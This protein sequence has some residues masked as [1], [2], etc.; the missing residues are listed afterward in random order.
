MS[1]DLG[2][3][4]CDE[5]LS[6]A[7]KFKLGFLLTEKSHEKTW[8]LSELAKNNLP[9]AI[10]VLKDL[11]LNVL[12]VLSEKLDQMNQ[13]AEKIEEVFADGGKVYLFGCG[14]T[15]R[16]SLLIESIWNQVH[17]DKVGQV[18][19]FMSGGDIALVQSVEGFEDQ[20]VYGAR[21]LNDL[22]FGEKD[23]LISSTEGGETPIVIGATLEATK[24]SKHKCYYLYC[25]PT[26]LLVDN[27][28]RSRQAIHHERVEPI[29]LYCG[30]MG[31][32]GSTRMQASSI[33]QIFISMAL[34][35]QKPGSLAGELEGFK[36]FFEQLDLS[37]L[38]A[39]IKE[40]AGIYVS[41]GR[42]TYNVDPQFALNTFTDTTERAPTF[43]MKPF[44]HPNKMEL[45]LALCYICVNG[46][47]NS[48]D[49]WE[50]LLFRKPRALGWEDSMA[51]VSDEYLKGFD[52][53][54]HAIAKR[55]KI[56]PTN[57]NFNITA[58]EGFLSWKLND[59]EYNI[60]LPKGLQFHWQ[61]VLLKFI[62]NTH[63]T[64]IMGRLRRYENNLM[65]WVSP[66]NGKLIDRTARYVDHFLKADGISKTYEEIVKAIFE[67]NL[68]KDRSM[69]LEIY[70]HI[71][72]QYEL[73][74]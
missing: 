14:A 72:R 71:K 39:F 5:Y 18:V 50:K 65:T 33:L 30:S 8:N 55:Q 41:F 4:N 69:V 28:E 46:A 45:P 24:I 11:D 10:N 54:H 7:Q 60:S 12:S 44:E 6:V 34:F 15:G 61:Q 74:K 66:S 21:H 73:T 47:E 35:R 2:F 42:L 16:L 36:K 3:K 63:S 68:R 26:D 13:L 22:K 37:F 70:H 29:E 49:A 52:F 53:S 17:P 48:M 31:I 25:N 56:S 67:I 20:V 58:N 59:L 43:S 40:E 27:I 23:L 64:L 32:A 9:E 51:R 19:S 57:N 38:E 62:L 1:E